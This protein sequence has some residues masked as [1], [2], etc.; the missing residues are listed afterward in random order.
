MAKKTELKIIEK[1]V[2]AIL[3]ILLIMVTIII[4]IGFY[5][6]YQ[7]EI[8]KNDYANIFGYT[9]FE[10]ATGSMSPTIEIGDVI[11][12]KITKEVSENDIIVYKDGKSIITHRLIKKNE[13]ELIAKTI[14]YLLI[15][16]ILQMQ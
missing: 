7:I 3:N 15:M 16:H 10:V 8:V 14:V 1:I 5:Y 6:I 2:S 9:F 13:E 12:T 4:G 11:I